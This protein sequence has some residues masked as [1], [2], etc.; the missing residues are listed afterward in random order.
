MG[1][2]NNF[3]FH[4][5]VVTLP[6]LKTYMWSLGTTC[7]SGCVV[8]ENIHTPPQRKLEIP[9]GAGEGVWGSMA[10]EIPEERM[11]ELLD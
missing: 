3:G 2:T 9:E 11:D 6:A 7:S 8:Q 1:R 5:M 4:G 10:Q